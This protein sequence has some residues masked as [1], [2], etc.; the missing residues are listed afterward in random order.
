MS[1]GSVSTKKPEKF[2]WTEAMSVGVPALDGDHQRLVRIVNLLRTAK[3]EGATSATIVT[4][5]E[6][7]KLYG[8]YHFRR[9]EHVME[10]IRFPGTVFHRAEHESFADYMDALRARYGSTRDP[11]MVDELFNYLT[12]WLRHHIL[13]QDMAY[14]PYVGAVRDVDRIAIEAA[15]CLPTL[16]IHP[17]DI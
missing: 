3:D 16:G 9:E 6:T 7:L 17:E 13:I 11:A 4:V 12:G 2:R 5:L 8:V 1:A 15:P 10:A 14:K